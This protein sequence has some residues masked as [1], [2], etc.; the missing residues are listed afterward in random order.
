MAAHD[1]VTKD[2]RKSQQKLGKLAN[3]GRHAAHTA[4][5]DLLPETARPAGP[6][7]P[8]GGLR[9]EPSPR[10]ATGVCKGQESLHHCMPPGAS[11][12][13]GP[14]LTRSRVRGHW[15]VFSWGQKNKW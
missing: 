13:L 1:V 9:L 12:G 11:M 14:S 7:D 4:S 3:Q 8:Q 2:S 5:L 10:L 6:D 15:K